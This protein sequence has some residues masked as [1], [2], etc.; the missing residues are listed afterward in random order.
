MRS[1]VLSR[2]T[3]VWFALLAATLASWEMGHGIGIHSVTHASIAI[4]IVSFVKVGFVMMEFMEL[5][6]A[7]RLARLL[8]LAWL[9]AISIVLIVLY[10]RAA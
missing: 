6:H 7:P 10:M 9:V 5:R 3:L 2:I 8:A 4:I 1:L